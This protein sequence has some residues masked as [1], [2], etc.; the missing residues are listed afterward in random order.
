MIKDGQV[1]ELF[2]LMDRGRSLA[3]AARKTGMDDKTARKYRWANQLPSQRVAP[4]QWRTRADPFEKV[5][6]LIEQRLQ[7]EPRL[8]AV[9]LF[10]WLQGLP[11]HQAKFPD[12]QRRTFERK[13]RTWRT[14][15]GPNQ[16]VMFAQ[17]HYPGD[18]AASD[19]THMDSLN[20]TLGGRPFP[21]LVYHFTLTYS[22]WESITVCPSE[23]FE[24]LSAGLQN[25]LW[26]LGGVPRRH[27]SDSLS[28]AV[29]NLSAEREF[30][31]RYVD[32]LAH[33]GLAGQRINV[34]QPHENGDA[35][36]SHGHFKDAVDQALRLRGSRDFASREEYLGFLRAVVAARNAKRQ[37]RFAAEVAAFQPL[38][39]QR[40][41][42]SRRLTD[43]TV[44]VGSTIQ[45]LKNTYSVHS[46]LIGQTVEVVIGVEEVQVWHAGILVQ[47]MPRLPGT[48]RHAINYR[49]IIDS[50][51]RKPGAFANYVYRDDLFPTS[52]FRRAYDSLCRQHAEKTATRQYL[53][54]LE[55]AAHESE[56]A[57]EDAL[58]AALAR[59]AEIS[60]AAVEA[61][62]RSSQQVPAVTE[63]RVEA[64]D[65]RVFDLLLDHP[66]MEVGS[67][68][69][70]ARE[71]VR[72]PVLDAA[73]IAALVSPARAVLAAGAIADAAGDGAADPCSER[74][75][76]G[77]A[78]PC[79]ERAIAG[80]AEDAAADARIERSV[81]DAA[82]DGGAD[83]GLARGVEGAAPGAALAD[84]PGALPEAGRAGGTGVVELPPVPGGVG[85]SGVPVASAAADPASA[86]AIASAAGQ[87]L[88][89][90]R[91][92]AD[93]VVGG[94]SGGEPAGGLVPGPAG[95][96][97]GVRQAGLGED[98][99][100]VCLGGAAGVSGPF[101][102]FHAVQPAGAEPAGGEAGL[103]VGEAAA[104]VVAVRGFDR[105]RPWLRAAQPGG[106]G[107]V[108]HAA[109][110]A[111]RAG[112]RM[113]DE[114][115]AVFAVGGDLQG[116]DDH[117]G[118]DRPAGASLRNLGAERAQLSAGDCPAEP[119]LVFRSRGR[120]ERGVIAL[121]VREF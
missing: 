34:R 104:A 84:V 65:L 92:E 5:W 35:E 69:F 53:K 21:H 3:F 13:V 118:G 17:V 41:E 52:H 102:P 64:P 96:P 112:E 23:S 19:F 88:G 2:R 83:A 100:R 61:A 47:R 63:V 20:V 109:G 31:Q 82:R 8:R 74:A 50:L 32:L 103:A 55:L 48:A 94:P 89:E 40:L 117:G 113:V 87:D 25:A 11:E 49:H 91:L 95:E 7:V 85:A 73:A 16:T 57:V 81:A 116:R 98:A 72:V 22:N 76:A 29:N 97:V 59:G 105:G 4:R 26:E 90:L 44:G 106:D 6:S 10:R 66:D 114:Q 71:E 9:T 15:Q 42:S 119:P 79:I 93:P 110:G 45:V 115:P 68:E 99:L 111:L 51:V 12:S 30:H 14:T 46:R 120:P 107:G 101:D 39:A 38:P 77:A 78:D 36:S 28:A 27:R 62:V 86:G 108:V 80:A 60:L 54:I 33:Y 58:R 43:I 18:L 56:A 37:E 24:A 70:S 1:R 67:H 121:C 75:I